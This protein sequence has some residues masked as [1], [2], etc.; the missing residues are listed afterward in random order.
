M[1]RDR[2]RGLFRRIV[3][4]G[5]FYTVSLLN[6]SGSPI[7]G[8]PQTWCTYGGL[9]G[10][11]NVSNGAPVGSCSTNG[12]FYPTPPFSS[13]LNGANTQSVGSNLNISGNLGVAGNISATGNLNVTGSTSFLGSSS[14]Q[15]RGGIVVDVSGTGCGDPRPAGS[16]HPQLPIRELAARA[17]VNCIS[18]VGKRHDLWHRIYSGMLVMRLVCGGLAVYLRGPFSMAIKRYFPKCGTSGHSDGRSKVSRA[19][20]CSSPKF[21]L[22]L[23]ADLKGVSP[24]EMG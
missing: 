2:I 22:H 24:P 15:F 1:H 6:K 16:P 10:T 14:T 17:T 12:V 21:K 20:P 19:E 8:F 7:S 9:T 18:A 11:I 5:T 23:E 3:L 4:T 13:Q